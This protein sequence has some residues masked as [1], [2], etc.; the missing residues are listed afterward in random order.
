MA[1]A[2]FD[3]D[4][5]LDLAIGKSY[6]QNVVY[7]NQGDGTFPELSRLSRQPLDG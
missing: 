2:D 3:G 7:L 6:Q 5:D 4:G 1:V